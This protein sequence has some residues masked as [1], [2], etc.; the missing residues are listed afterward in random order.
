MPSVYAA[1]VVLSILESRIE[2][3][4]SEAQNEI[5][6]LSIWIFGFKIRIRIF[7]SVCGRSQ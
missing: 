4:D 2:K 6:E 5:S 1:S 7:R 3:L